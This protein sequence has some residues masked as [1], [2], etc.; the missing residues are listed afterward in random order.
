MELNM[1]VGQLRKYVPDANKA[2]KP[3]C[4]GIFFHEGGSMNKVIFPVIK[5]E[6]TVVP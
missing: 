3:V 2:A 1:P 4:T 6:P 5:I